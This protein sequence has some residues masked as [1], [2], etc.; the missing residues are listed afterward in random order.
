MPSVGTLGNTLPLRP[1]NLKV[2]CQTF[3]HDGSTEMKE[4]APASPSADRHHGA[5]AKGAT[6]CGRQVQEFLGWHRGYPL[7]PDLLLWNLLLQNL[8]HLGWYRKNS[9]QGAQRPQL[10]QTVQQCGTYPGEDW[11]RDFT[12]MPISQ[13]YKYLQVMIDT[14]TGWIEGFPTWTEK[15]EEV[16]KKLLHEII[17]RFVCEVI[18]KW[19]WDIVY[20]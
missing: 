14:L 8:Y 19:Q 15:A 2:K 12:Q 7:C 11:Q 9:L 3:P 4:H 20:F 16:V 5:G 1:K 6:G 10:V 13:G 17:S 18:T